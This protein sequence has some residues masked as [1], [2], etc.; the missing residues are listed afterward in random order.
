M[1]VEE[2]TMKNGCTMSIEQDEKWWWWVVD[3]WEADGNNRWNRRY[4]DYAAAKAEFERWRN[5]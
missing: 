2:Y 4:K 1:I 3:Q 5:Y